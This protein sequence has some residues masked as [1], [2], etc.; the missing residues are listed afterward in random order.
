MKNIILFIKSFGMSVLAMVIFIIVDMSDFLAGWLC[1]VV[2]LISLMCFSNYN[3][4]K[5]DKK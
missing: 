2:F 5:G 4:V 3:I 1:C